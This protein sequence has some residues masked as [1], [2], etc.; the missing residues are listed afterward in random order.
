MSE[1]TIEVHY[2]QGLEDIKIA[3]I[4]SCPGKE[5]EKAKKPVA[6]QSGKN[7]DLLL[8]MLNQKHPELF[9]YTDRYNYRITNAWATVEHEAK[10]GRSEAKPSE[11]RNPL[12]IKRMREEIHD[13]TSVIF[14]GKRAQGVI[15]HLNLDG[16]KVIHSRHTSFQC[17]NRMK[18]RSKYDCKKCVRLSN[19]QQRLEILLDEIS[20]QL[21]GQYHDKT[22]QIQPPHRRSAM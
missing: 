2:N 12:N 16:I 19:T 10:T 9:L 1:E 3:F 17:L 18:L 8:T 14:F 5:E 6:G 11:I 15:K 13:M 22:R 7:L 4:F 21:K 20:K